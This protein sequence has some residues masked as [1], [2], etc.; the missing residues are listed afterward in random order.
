VEVKNERE[1]R[2]KKIRIGRK[3]EWMTKREGKNK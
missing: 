1:K 3:C 2:K